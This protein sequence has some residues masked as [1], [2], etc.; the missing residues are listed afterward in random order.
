MVANENQSYRLTHDRNQAS[1]SAKTPFNG[2]TKGLPPEKSKTM[3][4]GDC[5]IACRERCHYCH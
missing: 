3:F 1:F 5:R 4:R 2:S